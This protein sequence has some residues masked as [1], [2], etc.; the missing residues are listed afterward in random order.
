MS[1]HFFKWISNLVSDG[2]SFGYS[3]CYCECFIKSHTRLIWHT[4]KVNFH[5]FTVYMSCISQLRLVRLKGSL[6]TFQLCY[7]CI[8]YLI[9]NLGACQHGE[10]T[11]EA[12]GLTYRSIAALCWF[13]VWTISE[14]QAGKNYS[15]SVGATYLIEHHY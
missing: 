11:A 14:H 4:D 6:C 3:S 10:F 9:W 2:L 8:V 12:V 7:S 1:K 5:L 15:V 13:S